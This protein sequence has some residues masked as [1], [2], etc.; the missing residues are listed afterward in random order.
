MYVTCIRFNTIVDFIKLKHSHHNRQDER[1]KELTKERRRPRDR[2][3]IEI[4][5]TGKRRPIT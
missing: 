3:I 5:R 2:G 1:N 4:Y